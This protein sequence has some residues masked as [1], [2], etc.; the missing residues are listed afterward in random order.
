MWGLCLIRAVQIRHFELSLLLLQLCCL[1]EII[2]KKC[3]NKNMTLNF[4]WINK[5]LI[6]IELSTSKLNTCN[7]EYP[8]IT[9]SIFPVHT[10]LKACR[11][12]CSLTFTT[13]NGFM[14]TASV[15]PEHNPARYK[16][17]KGREKINNR[18]SSRHEWLHLTHYKIH[19]VHTAVE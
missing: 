11:S 6:R 13:S 16:I 2:I 9:V 7:F 4:N 19:I 15:S 18:K 12:A 10:S 8:V 3:Y 17:Y 5:S 1:A 14:I